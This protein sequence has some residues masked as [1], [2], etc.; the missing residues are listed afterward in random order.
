MPVDDASS[1]FVREQ[2]Q[3]GLCRILNA[4]AHASQVCATPKPA[5]WVPSN[6]SSLDKLIVSEVV[7]SGR[8]STTCCLQR[9]GMAF[10][11]VD[12]GGRHGR[13]YCLDAVRPGRCK[14]ARL[15]GEWRWC[16]SAI[17]K[18]KLDAL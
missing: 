10:C 18:N 4:I 2:Y 15:P 9:F 3:G 16:W 14:L 7:P 6:P 8:H 12:C 5:P 17:G 13:L 11:P 1:C